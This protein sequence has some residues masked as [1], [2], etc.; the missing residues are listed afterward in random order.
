MR[1][2][3]DSNNDFFNANPSKTKVNEKCI[4]TIQFLI[5]YKN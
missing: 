4:L 3:T 1:L 5:L 2:F